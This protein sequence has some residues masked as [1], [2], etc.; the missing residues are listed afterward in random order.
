MNLDGTGAPIAP[1]ISSRQC[2]R[3]PAVSPSSRAAAPR[4]QS[5]HACPDRWPEA[6]G[7]LIDIGGHLV[8]VAAERPQQR[9][10]RLDRLERWE[11]GESSQVEEQLPVARGRILWRQLDRPRV[12]RP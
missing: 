6:G 8:T 3:A 2:R 5:D 7:R 4:I 9:R 11:S 12:P 1:Q 10:Q